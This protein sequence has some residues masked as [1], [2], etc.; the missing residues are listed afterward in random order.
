MLIFIAKNSSVRFIFSAFFCIEN[1]ILADIMSVGGE[2]MKKAAKKKPGR[3]KGSKAQKTREEPVQIRV[4]PEEKTAYK[5]AA[6]RT[7][8]SM[9]AW[10]RM[11]LNREAER[12]K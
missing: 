3:P 1:V 6:E 8:L 10:M 4:L 12:A 5:A 2:C 11:T 9:S 7:G